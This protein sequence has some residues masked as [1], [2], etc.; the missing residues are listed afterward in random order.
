MKPEFIKKLDHLV[1]PV[2]ISH[3]GKKKVKHQDA[4]VRSALIIRPG[5]IGDAVLLLPMLQQLSL[6]YPD[7]KIEVLAESR[8]A[9]VFLWS[10]VVSR[11]WQYDRPLEFLRLFRQRY[12][13]I[14]D[15][16]QWYRLSAVVAR[17]LSSSRSIGFATNERSN[18]LTDPCPYSQDEY[19]AVMFVRLLAPLGA[20]TPDLPADCYGLPVLP[21]AEHV[22]KN[23][24]VVIFPGASVAAKQWPAERFAEVASYCEEMGF[25]VVVVG[26]KAEQDSSQVISRTLNRCHDLAGTTG[27]TESAAIVCGASLCISGDSGLLH[28]AQLKGVPTIALFG[29][30][31][32]KKWC[33]NDNL[34]VVVT[35]GSNCAP[36]SLFGTI[37]KC[38]HGFQC[39]QNI[40][41]EMVVA[42]VTSLLNKQGQPIDCPCLH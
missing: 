21:Q 36:C 31:N 22:F 41:V 10:Q 37:P 17:L 27:L 30:S 6:L 15:T 18:L 34:H 39:M 25:D 28:V 5:G 29:P 3:I 9:E 32:H 8:N 14:I 42:A 13:L 20:H 2:F 40:T 12:D 26:G 24:Y 19:E 23:P 33:R 1:V 7:A 38:H 35:A 16:E 4:L 11:I